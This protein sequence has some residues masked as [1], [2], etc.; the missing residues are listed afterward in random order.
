MEMIAHLRTQGVHV[1][2]VP[3]STWG[4]N[5]L[6]SLP[7]LTSGDIIDVHSYGGAGELAR[8]PQVEPNLVHWIAAAHVVGRP[9][10]VSEWGL[11]RRGSLAADRQD[12]PLFVAAWASMQGWNAV[13]LYAYA[14]QPFTAGRSSPAVYNAFDDPALMASMP[15]A[16]LLYRQ[17]HVSEA[18]TPT[19]SHPGRRAVRGLDVTRELR[20]AAHRCRE[21]QA[22]DRDARRSRLCP[23]STRPGYRPARS[24]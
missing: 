15:A 22:A 19:C 10:S 17:G 3:T 11:D 1:P 7:A 12:V 24:A 23:G 16:A 4:R 13:L 18:R 14:M 20:G 21:R 2:I 6:G 9:L 5:P 8:D